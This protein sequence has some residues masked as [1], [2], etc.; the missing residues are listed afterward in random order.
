MLKKQYIPIWLL[1]I[2]L[3]GLTLLIGLEIKLLVNTNKHKQEAVDKTISIIRAKELQFLRISNNFFSDTINTN[4]SFVTIK[5]LAASNA[6]N[7]NVFKLDTLRFWNN[8]LLNTQRYLKIIQPGTRFLLAN[9][10]YYLTH[11]SKFGNWVLVQ[12]YQIKTNYQYQNQYIVNHFNSEL[13]FLEGAMPSPS[14]LNDFVNITDSKGNFLFAIQVY[15]KNRLT[16]LWLKIF[17][18]AFIIAILYFFKILIKQFIQYNTW[19][20]SLTYF[21]LMLGAKYVFLKLKIPVFIYNLELFSPGYYATSTFIPSLGDFFILVAILLWYFIIL[22]NKI[23]VSKLKKSQSV[24]TLFVVSL[25]TATLTDSALDGLK[26]L[27]NDSQ[28]TFDLN[29]FQSLNYITL[30]AL[31][32]GIC[33]LFSVYLITKRFYLVFKNINLPVVKK[34]IITV[35]AFYIIHPYIVI[36]LFERNAYYPIVNTTAILIFLAY[37][38]WVLQKINRLQQYLILALMFSILASVFIQYWSG[39]REQENRKLY[40]DKLIAQNDINTEIYLSQIENRIA[41]DKELRNYFSNPLI[42]QK[43]LQRRLR[44]LYFTGHLS[45]YDITLYDYDSALNY[46]S[47]RNLL[48]YKQI[49]Y[50]YSDLS[51]VTIAT[52]FKLLKNSSYIKGYLGKFAVKH[53]GKVLGYVFIQLQPKLLIDENRFDEL[54][55]EGFKISSTK[56]HQDY[57]YAIYRDFRLISQSGM[58]NYHMSYVWPKP[59]QNQLFINDNGYNHLILNDDKNSIV[60]VS[61]KS[62]ALF[63]PF[64]LFSLYFTF[65]TV[66]LLVSLLF[67]Y[68]IQSSLF[69]QLFNKY[70]STWHIVLKGFNKL[71]L[72]NKNEVALLRSKI[73]IAVVLIVF[74]TLSITAVFTINLISESYMQKQTDKLVQKLRGVVSALE[75]DILLD[76]NTD[77]IEADAYLNQIGEYYNTDITFFNTGG[78]VVSSTISKIYDNGI[79]APVI[80]ADAYY[81]LN[82][83]QESRYINNE[84]IATFDFIGAYLPVVSKKKFIVGYVML[85]YF[86]KQADLYAELASI[87][88][89]FINLYA[90]LFIVIGIL[91]WLVSRN[92]TFPLALIE[93]Q[94]ANI[95]LNK[96]NE[97]INW[98]KDDEI[99][100]LVQQYNKMI[101]QLQHSAEILAQSERESAWRDIARQIA[102]EIKNPLTPMKLSVQHLERAWND[103]SP[104]LPDTFKRVTKTLITQIDTL[105]DLAGE[106]SNYAKMPQPKPT[107]IDLIALLQTQINANEQIIESGHI[108]FIEP[109]ENINLYFDEGFLNRTFTNLIKNAIQAVPEEETVNIEIGIT[110]NNNYVVVWVKDN[111]TGIDSEKADRIFTP[112]FS[113]KSFGMGLGLPIVKSMIEVS[114]GKIWFKNNPDKG[115]TFFVQIPFNHEP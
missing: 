48:T 15:E 64:G 26:S 62:N 55:M 65:F 70:F 99:G 107:T 113:T 49:D 12:Y 6:I 3:L 76:A 16:P 27:V 30:F 40:A 1:P 63:E 35:F 56:K 112:Y 86:N 105:S 100:R 4:E 108:T 19:L 21:V 9:N 47:D 72:V 68:I 23:S 41:N 22:G 67:N 53:A 5:N 95:S 110:T 37:I 59:I 54:L 88:I 96:R 106:F 83:L 11:H 43:Q 39:N 69:V 52:N 87:I 50:A 66:A 57:S 8:N 36:N 77:K 97:P 90:F 13:D 85:P 44:Q 114:G 34:I 91:A 103:N 51:D 109:K 78:Q 45:K 14:P 7:V 38:H 2:L 111:G 79:I 84:R 42:L 58:F 28:L 101:D 25:F 102:H 93:K 10:G 24:A 115:T 61:K 94:L 71:L 89:G 46:Y 98:Q 92:I 33:L 75:T 32:L 74:S 20:A 81:K 60:V 104:K 18:L 29:N 73:Q 17:I 80:D 82:N 31:L